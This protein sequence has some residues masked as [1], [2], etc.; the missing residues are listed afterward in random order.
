MEKINE[1][2][3]CCPL[4]DLDTLKR[5]S[6]MTFDEVSSEDVLAFGE[7]GISDKDKPEERIEKVLRSGRNPYFRRSKRGDGM[8]KISFANNGVTLS[9]AFANALAGM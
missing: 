5:M 9:D 7:I 3:S 1:G 2:T 4:P 6:S 8:V